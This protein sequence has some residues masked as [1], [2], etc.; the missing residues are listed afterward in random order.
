MA[1]QTPQQIMG[2]LIDLFSNPEKIETLE[3]T[4]TK[5]FIEGNPCGEW[6][7]GNRL[8]MTLQGTNDARGFRQWQKVGRNPMDW[9]KQVTI[10]A[11]LVRKIHDEKK[12]EDKT[13]ITGFKSI[14]LYAVENTYG[15][16]LEDNTPKE[17]PPLAEIAQEW[18][19]S[20]RYEKIKGEWGHY[21]PNKKEIV[22]GTTDQQT[23][24][25][26]LAHV[27]HEKID[28][29]LSMDDEKYAMQEAIAQL[30]SAVLAR[31]YGVKVDKY[32]FEYIAMYAKSHKPDAVGRMCLKVAD[33][34]GKVLEL[35]LA[36][37]QKIEVV[38]K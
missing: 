11:P 25:H 24:F 20:V 1:K 7:W 18:G 28:G 9:Q 8:L 33:K 5:S 17:L 12:Q 6:S 29:K 30:T 34:V 21:S 19:I 37:K 35:I 22:L 14:G 16:K 36:E 10:I 2:E 3:D 4:V 15:R 23:F 38:A 26:E 31:I 27:A 32:T 13:I